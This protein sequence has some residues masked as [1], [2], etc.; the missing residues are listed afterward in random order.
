[1]N[2]LIKNRNSEILGKLIRNT[3]LYKIIILLGM[4]YMIL[5]T[6]IFGMFLKNNNLLKYGLGS[7]F[8]LYSIIRG[9]MVYKVVTKDDEV[10]K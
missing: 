3:G 9:I 10:V 1:M 7:S 2:N 4:G 5:F 6:D 8:F